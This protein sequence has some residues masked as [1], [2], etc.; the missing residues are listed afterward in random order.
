MGKA[1]RNK[2]D[3]LEVRRAEADKKKKEAA[4]AKKRSL[5]NKIIGTVCAVLAVLLIGSVVV[6]NKLET[7]GF[8]L[9]RVPA[10]TSTNYTMDG[11]MASYHFYNQYQNFLSMYGSSVS[12]FGLDT[13]KSLKYQECPMYEDGTTWYK[14]FMDNAIQEMSDTLVFCEEAAA[15]GI[16]LDEADYEVIDAQIEQIKEQAKASNVTTGFFITNIYGQGVK[17]KDVRRAMEMSL[18]YSKC[19]NQIMSEYTYTEDDYKA[20][21]EENPK[22]LLRATYAAMS[23]STS[24]GMVEGDVTVDLLKEFET[25][26]QAVKNKE[27]FDAVSFDYLM[28][29]AYKN[30]TDV[31]EEGV[32][33]E[34]AGHV[35]ENGGYTE[36]DGGFMKWAAEDGRKANEVYT[37]WSNEG[38]TLSVCI[39]LEPLTLPE[40]DTVNIRHILLT[41]DTYGSEDAAKAKAEELLAQWQAG[42]ATADSFAALANEYSE[43]TA[44]NGLY[45]NV[46][47]GQMMDAFDAWMYEDGRKAGDT[48]I[49]KTTYGY[50]VMYMDSFGMPAWHKEA[51]DI[52]AKAD[53][54]EDYKALTD[55]YPVHVD[56]I[57]LAML[58]V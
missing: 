23:L 26:F 13:S 20:Y 18:L 46:L 55:K 9:R 48:G 11:T 8:Y 49:V 14:V 24:D 37:S 44:E 39:L 5:R 57:A 50:H 25:K 29:H 12:Y 19:Y 22:S 21:V 1:S 42:D 30:Y 7:S 52:L 31:T 54:D 6:Y 32:R 51:N 53:Y 41:A 40:Y 3:N 4:L 56:R 10:M 28:N 35:I 58:D 2:R 43:D 27:E 36:S 16:T 45:E 47:K 17:E 15:R 34:V 38:N 33:E